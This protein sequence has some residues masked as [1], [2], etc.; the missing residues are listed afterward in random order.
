MCTVHMARWHC[1]NVADSNFYCF[2]ASKNSLNTLQA[3]SYSRCFRNSE[4]IRRLRWLLLNL[5]LR[6]VNGV[7]KTKTSGGIRSSGT[8]KSYTNYW[9]VWIRKSFKT[10]RHVSDMSVFK[11]IFFDA[12]GK[13]NNFID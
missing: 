2:L 8:C 11:K 3:A 10:C 7:Q 12:P 4:G 6:G 13:P 9:Y 5:M 1:P